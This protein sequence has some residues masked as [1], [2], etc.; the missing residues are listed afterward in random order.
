MSRTIEAIMRHMT[1]P[2][3]RVTDQRNGTEKLEKEITKKAA[4]WVAGSQIR[5]RDDAVSLQL[6]RS[7]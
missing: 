2:S 4:S 6:A 1:V 7:L 3:N 5:S